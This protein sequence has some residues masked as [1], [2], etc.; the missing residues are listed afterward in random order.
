MCVARGASWNVRHEN[1]CDGGSK[2]GIMVR[3]RKGCIRLDSQIT[4]ELCDVMRW[5][6]RPKEYSTA[7]KLDGGGKTKG[8]VRSDGNPRARCGSELGEL[9]A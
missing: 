8:T 5:R 2:S 4:W 9:D 1:L 3:R 7:R 6:I